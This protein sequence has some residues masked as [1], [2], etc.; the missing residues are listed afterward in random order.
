[1]KGEEP[2]VEET[3]VG[4]A[5]LHSDTGWCSVPRSPEDEGVGGSGCKAADCPRLVNDLKDEGVEGRKGCG[6]GNEVWSLWSV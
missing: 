2:I 3:G 5:G 6:P 1:M 4:K